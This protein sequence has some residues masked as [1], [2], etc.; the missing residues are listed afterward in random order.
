MYL[1]AFCGERRRREEERR[2]KDWFY[3]HFPEIVETPTAVHQPP[4]SDDVAGST[5]CEFLLK[6]VPLARERV[7]S[8]GKV[9]RAADC[10]KVKRT[11]PI[12]QPALQ[13]AALSQPGLFILQIYYWR[14][15]TTN[16]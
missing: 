2:G 6:R 13:R 4:L 10:S 14:G 1:R 12:M 9:S 16:Y 3:A 15:V 7:D 8:I 5:R 11:T